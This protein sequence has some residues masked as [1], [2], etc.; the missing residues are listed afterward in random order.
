MK[1][2]V[3]NLLRGARAYFVFG[4]T[5]SSDHITFSG[6]GNLYVNSA[7][8]RGKAIL[9]SFGV[10]Q[11]PVTLFWRALEQRL[12]PTLLLDIGANHG[13]I[14][15]S[16]RY[17]QEARIMLFEPNPVLR[18]FLERSISTH[19]N[20]SQI[21]LST[22]LVSDSCVEQQF[23]VDHKWSGT[24]S[25]IKPIVDESNSFKGVGPENSEEIKIQS[26]RIDDILAN[27]EL[28]DQRL[29]FKIDVEGFEPRVIGGMKT[30]LKNVQ[31][32]AGIIEFDRSY[33]QAG[34]TDPNQFF[35]VLQNFGVAMT[36]GKGSLK[37]IG[38]YSDIPDH[39]DIVIGSAESVLAD[40]AL[41]TMARALFRM[42]S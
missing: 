33:L 30:T 22:S 21:S 17:R 28:G 26:V 11:P 7:D 15:L 13:E 40:L 23:F 14:S 2:F 10:M 20:R 42:S 5:R 38:Q 35:I 29:L 16:I 32:F 34:G 25:A 8:N 37:R 27:R 1:L 36:M 4:S 24:S 18:P 41:P 3:K 31:A 39:T 6:V 12:A 9:N 19:I